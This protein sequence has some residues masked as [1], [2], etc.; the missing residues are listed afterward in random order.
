[1]FTNQNNWY[2]LYSF[3][4]KPSF[5]Y[6]SFKSLNLLMK[7]EKIN[8]LDLFVII[9]YVNFETLREEGYVLVSNN[10]IGESV[11]ESIISENA[12]NI[13][14]IVIE[15]ISR[16]K[17][18][19]QNAYK[20]KL[21]IDRNLLSFKDS[22]IVGREF[23]I[24]VELNQNE[25][26]MCR[27]TDVSDYYKIHINDKEFA[28]NLKLD[29]AKREYDKIAKYYDTYNEIFFPD[30]VSANIIDLVDTEILKTQLVKTNGVGEGSM[31][32]DKYV[33]VKN[34]VLVKMEKEILDLFV[35]IEQDDNFNCMLYNFLD[36][37]HGRLFH[38]INFIAELELF[39]ADQFYNAYRDLTVYLTMNTYKSVETYTYSLVEDF[40]INQFDMLKKIMMKKF[41]IASNELATFT[42]LKLLYSHS[43]KYSHDKFKE[44]YGQ[45]F[46]NIENMTLNESILIYLEIDLISD[47]GCENKGKFIKFLIAE[48]MFKDDCTASNENNYVKCYI[49]FNNIFNAVLDMKKIDDYE[50]MLMS[51]DKI[52]EESYTINDIDLMDGHEFEHLLAMLFSRMGYKTTVTKGSGDQGIDV[53][54]EKFGKKIGIQA[55]CYSSAVTN[56]AIQEVVAGIK[57]YNLDK[58]MVVTNNYY[59][60]SA[61]ELAITNNVILW[62]RTVLSEKLLIL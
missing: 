49:E 4:V 40:M 32:K 39:I 37:S 56:S 54:A 2:I 51:N 31:V 30:S 52:P 36:K 11:R 12:T 26:I 23:D 34:R 24:N 17:Y 44:E 10:K 53:I 35:L 16:S 57:H 38:D 13:G 41:N 45:Y 55:K 20:T 58:A 21:I 15:N 22:D 60:N 47:W 14:K 59:T 43:I 62:D 3:R 7:I 50:K 48:S 18:A 33:D 28:I 8:Y 42:L 25:P 27:F 29:E 1:M 19:G 6:I 61:K 5:H 9:E 46:K